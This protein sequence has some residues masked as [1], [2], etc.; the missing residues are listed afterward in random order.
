VESRKLCRLL[1]VNR[2]W[3]Y[4]HRRPS[5]H[6]EDDQRLRVAIQEIREVEAFYGY[7]RVTKALAR[8]GGIGQSQAGLGVVRCHATSWFDLPAQATHGAYH[9]FET[10]LPD[11]PE[12]GE[13][14]AGRGAQPLLG[15]G[16]DLCTAARGLCVPGLLAGRLFAHMYWVEPVSAYRCAAA[17]A[18]GL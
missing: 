16:P 5:A 9:R 14:T 3:Y 10:Q 11:L 12:S 18:S 7:R 2:Q 6:Q 8:A 4:Q 13:G 1:L 17:T 15:G